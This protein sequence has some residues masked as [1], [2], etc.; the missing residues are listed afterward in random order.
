MTLRLTASTALLAFVVSTCP[1]DPA[2]AAELEAAEMMRLDPLLTLGGLT[3]E[4]YTEG[5][6][7]LVVPLH[8]T[9]QG[10]WFLNPRFSFT[11]RSAEEYNLGLGYRHLMADGQ[12]IGGVN[13]FYDRRETARGA[14]FNQIGAGLEYLSGIVDLRANIY[15]PLENRKRVGEFST[16]EE[17]VLRSSSVSTALEW[18]DPFAAGHDV[19]QDFSVV[20]STQTRTTT[21]T[22]TRHFHEYEVALRGWDAE[23]GAHLPIE[24][25]QDYVRLKPF[26][27][28]YKYYGRDGLDDVDGFRGRLEVHIKPSFFIDAVYY[29]DDELTG[30]NYSIGAYVSLP[31]NL[32]NIAR[33]RNPFEGAAERWE[34]GKQ[35]ENMRYRLTDMVKRDP[36]IRSV[37]AEPEEQ[38]E[39]TTTASRS[40][41]RTDRKTLGRGTEELATDIT[42]VDKNRGNDANPGTFEDPK[43]TVQGGVDDPRSMVFVFQEGNPYNEIVTMTENVILRG[44][45]APIQGFGGKVF[46]SGV[47]PTINAT[48][49][50]PHAIEMAAN[51]SVSGFRINNAAGNGIFSSTG[52]NL[53]MANNIIHNTVQGVM[54]ETLGDVSVVLENNQFFDNAFLG[55]FIDGTG[56]SGSFFVNARNNTFQGGGAYGLRLEATDYDNALAV[57]HGLQA[58][59]TVFGLSASLAA[60][61]VSL[62]SLSDIQAN[63][64]TFGVLADIESGGVAAMLGGIPPELMDFVGDLIGGGPLP[65]ELEALLASGGP[66]QVN[67]NSVMGMDIQVN[68]DSLAALL[69]LDIEAN[70]NDVFGVLAEVE[71]PSGV[72]LGLVGSSQAFLES[73]Q[74]L[75][76]LLGFDPGDLPSTST[77]YSQFNNNNVGGLS[78]DVEGDFLALAA[79]IGI[80]ANNNQNYHGIESI[81]RSPNGVALNLLGRIEANNNDVMGINAIAEGDFFGLAALFDTHTSGND[82]YGVN[83]DVSGEAA[84]GLM[85]STD[86]L[87]TLADILNDELALDPP[88]MIP[89]T[90]FGPVIASDNGVMGVN[91]NINGEFLALGAFLDVHATGNDIFGINANINSDDGIAIGLFASSDQLFDVLFPLL[92]EPV[93]SF[94]P[95]GP[96]NLSGNNGGL[97]ANISGED[98]AFGLAA[99]IDASNNTDTSGPGWG[100]DVNVTSDDGD[101]FAA[102][103]NITANNNALY[104][105]RLNVAAE[106]LASANVFNAE[107]GGNGLHGMLIDV[108]S[109]SDD[110][111]LLMAGI[112]AHNN[113]LQGIFA[114]VS[115]AGDV[116]VA[117]SDVHASGNLREGLWLDLDAGQDAFVWMGDEA[118]GDFDDVFGGIGF[119]GLPPGFLPAGPSTFNNN[120]FDPDTPG[121]RAGMRLVVDAEDEILVSISDA[122]FNANSGY[123]LHTDLVSANDDISVFLENV[124]A[125]NNALTGLRLIMDNSAVPAGT[126][127]SF[128]NLSEALDNGVPDILVRQFYSSVG[129]S[130]ISIISDS[131]YDSSTVEQI[132]L[133]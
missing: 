96:M 21:T 102:L 122:T 17:S 91:A 19:W 3:T 113:A 56:A 55:A 38:E 125:N 15:V 97:F 115:A 71:S 72:A 9:G 43:Q 48:G 83:M 130:A 99:G 109:A 116:G 2:C 100:L 114:D 127:F 119:V 69:L 34:A 68:G 87:R 53:H 110:A 77:G 31:L 80:Q 1:L 14:S 70:R 61:F 51:T 50:G 5:I 64:N 117:L 112:Q 131:D 103:L 41:T 88:L 95:M 62:L 26:A 105:V 76:G 73:L 7:D 57:V 63:N 90:P 20:R 118:F 123:G 25:I 107:A 30:G 6:G 101:A 60:D 32:A 98:A 108:E 37:M 94:T 47:H 52:E 106:W 65:P 84:I 59:D 44:E 124:T 92:G 89:G 12:S 86:P 27:G 8:F 33:G 54:V 75:G 22:T 104:G 111:F 120:G 11:D 67:D 58:S 79:G 46:G 23:I 121:Q 13:V 45:G 36:Q 40:A 49:L 28:Y 4:D 39:L 129:G 18:D 132:A 78:L 42:F 126:V 128:I 29:S 35:T 133:P 10:L 16:E 24:Q 74:L 82:V 93:P 66:I 85:A 81:A